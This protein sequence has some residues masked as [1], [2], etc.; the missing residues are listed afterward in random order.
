MKQKVFNADKHFMGNL[1]LLGKPMFL[2]P[3][4]ILPSVNDPV[5]GIWVKPL[6]E[7]N[8]K[9][10]G[11]IDCFYIHTDPCIVIMKRSVKVPLDLV[12]HL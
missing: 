4:S 6:S 5:A 7:F 3:C 11:G 1:A 12:R 8:A 2:L 10:S 9:Y